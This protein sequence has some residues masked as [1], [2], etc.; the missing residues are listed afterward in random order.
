MSVL[1]ILTYPDPKLTIKCEP[2]AV[3]DD[4]IKQQVADMIDTMY[5]EQGIGL[6]A[7]QVGFLNRVTTIDV[8]WPLAGKREPKVFINP[9]ITWYSDETGPYCEGCLS[10]PGESVEV[11][12]PLQITVEYLDLEGNKCELKTDGLFARCIQHEIDH[13]DGKL[14]VDHAKPLKRQ[15]MVKRLTKRKKLA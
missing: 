7:P 15:M 4:S 14:L 5:H 12:R 8:N 2:V 13:L 11:T 6:A 9:V 3:I 1:P 10:I